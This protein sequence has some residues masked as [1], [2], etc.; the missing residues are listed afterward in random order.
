[1]LGRALLRVRA[2][3]IGH[4]FFSLKWSV[5]STIMIYSVLCNS[6]S[7]NIDLFYFD[8]RNSKGNREISQMG[9]YN[10]YFL[11]RTELWDYLF[12]MRENSVYH[13]SSRHLLFFFLCK[14][15]TF[16]VNSLT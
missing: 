12:S 1:M 9:S 14:M 3:K 6:A 13:N 16:H 11:F 2:K 8:L 5:I 10:L 7:C 15:S 4:F